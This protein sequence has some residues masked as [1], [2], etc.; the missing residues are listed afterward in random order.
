[1]GAREAV[2][3]RGRSLKQMP[4]HLARRT[5]LP[6]RTIVIF[7]ASGDLT[8]RKLLPALFHLYLEGLLPKDLAVIGYGRTPYADDEYRESAYDA[9]KRHGAHPP[10]GEPWRNFAMRLHY[11]T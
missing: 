5:R 1:M 2:A 6:P 4:F 10:E 7:G 3:T 11:V 8:H 9:V